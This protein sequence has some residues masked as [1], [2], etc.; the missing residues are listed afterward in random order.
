MAT[1]KN[2]QIDGQTVRAQFIGKGLFSKAYRVENTV[3][4]LTQGDYSKECIALF[5]RGQHIPVITRHEDIEEGRAMYQVFS[6]PFYQPMRKKHSKAW[7]QWAFLK[8]VCVVPGGYFEVR[9]WLD[10]DRVKLELEP[11][12][13]DALDQMIEAFSNYDS[14]SMGLEFNKV[15]VS[16]D[17]KGELILRDVLFSQVSARRLMEARARKV[18]RY[19]YR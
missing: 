7:K 2:L 13:W 9:E 16:V 19:A 14:E 12:V 15:N 11:T 10:S 5:A 3:Y 4:L 6:M 1:F 18:N 17:E 8:Q